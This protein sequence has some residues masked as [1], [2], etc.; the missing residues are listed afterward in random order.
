MLV[1][2]PRGSKNVAPCPSAVAISKPK[3]YL[4]SSSTI[5]G[6]WLPR[7]VLSLPTLVSL[8]NTNPS[9]TAKAGTA[10]NR[11]GSVSISGFNVVI[12]DNL[13]VE[14]PA[15]MVP[16]AEFASGGPGARAPPNEVTVRLLL[17]PLSK[18]N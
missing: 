12:P 2:F 15:L 5:H 3:S 14:F 10:L 8:T 7:Q 6:N 13:I 11:G 4:R 16:F 1:T 9:A 18:P 17:P